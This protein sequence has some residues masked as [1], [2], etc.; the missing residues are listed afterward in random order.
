ML[1]QF[2]HPLRAQSELY[3]GTGDSRVVN[4]IM[5]TLTYR[6]KSYVQNKTIANK[7]L[8]ELKYRRNVYMNRSK[9]VSASKINTQLCYRGTPYQT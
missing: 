5:I 6:G 7:Q 9:N 3:H 2:V 8:V 4:R 1:L